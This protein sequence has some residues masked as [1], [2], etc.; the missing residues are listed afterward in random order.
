MAWENV[1]RRQSDL[2]VRLYRDALARWRRAKGGTTADQMANDIVSIWSKA[3]DVWWGPFN[4]GDPVLPTLTII[5]RVGRGPFSGDA[6]LVEDTT[7]AQIALTPLGLVGGNRVL[8]G[9]RGIRVIRRSILRVEVSNVPA[10]SHAN[11]STNLYQG[12]AMRGNEP[13]AVIMVKVN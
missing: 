9:N 13:V 11:N 5:A 12:L 1:A 10:G 8:G 4:G 7:A 6:R 2:M 3:M